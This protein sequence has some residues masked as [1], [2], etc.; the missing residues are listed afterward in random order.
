MDKPKDIKNIKQHLNKGIFVGYTS[1][2]KEEE[3]TDIY[4]QMVG[5]SDNFLFALLY[6]QLN[7]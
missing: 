1:K 4:S 3:L 2:G 7:I 6:F 5:L